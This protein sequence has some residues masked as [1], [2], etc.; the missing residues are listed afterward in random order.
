[1]KVLLDECLPVDLRRGFTGHEVH[2]AE[3][4]G[5]KGMQN[6][7]LLAAAEMAGYQLLV[8]TDQGFPSQQK[9]AGRAI[10]IVV[11]RAPTNK[12]ADLTPL[13]GAIEQ[14]LARAQAGN[15]YIVPIPEPS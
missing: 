15:A 8:T 9:L 12:I 3:W 7:E 6:G 14:V 11:V 10:A 1:M 5:F 4:A 2:T 13:I